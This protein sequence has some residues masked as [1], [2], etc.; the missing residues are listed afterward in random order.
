MAE[1]PTC[2]VIWDCSRDIVRSYECNEG[3]PSKI[4]KLEAGPIMGEE[5]GQRVSEEFVQILSQGEPRDTT[6][7]VAAKVGCNTFKKHNM[8]WK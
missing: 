8:E 7:A 6:C 2:I 1:W 4:Q 5:N 3:K